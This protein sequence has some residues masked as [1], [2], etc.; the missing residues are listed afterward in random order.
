MIFSSAPRGNGLRRR[1]SALCVGS[2]SSCSP[3]SCLVLSI[4]IS[5]FPVRDTKKEICSTDIIDRVTGRGKKG[6]FQP[7]IRGC[8]PSIRREKAHI[9]CACVDIRSM[10]LLKKGCFCEL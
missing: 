1:G 10:R 9:L 6:Q 5:F 2:P 4:K 8:F 7:R 3:L